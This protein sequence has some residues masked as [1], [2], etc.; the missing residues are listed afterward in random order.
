LH[1]GQKQTEQ[2]DYNLN[3]QLSRASNEV[4]Q[5]DLYRH[6]VAYQWGQTRS[7]S[8][9]NQPESSRIFVWIQSVW[10]FDT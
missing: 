10:I 8:K 1:T 7:H 4:S 2:F 5:I 3:S 9:A 6:S